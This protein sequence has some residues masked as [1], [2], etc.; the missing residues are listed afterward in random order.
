MAN[1][2]L[3]RHG[4]L[5]GALQ[6][7]CA[8]ALT[9]GL[10]LS[11]AAFAGA[12]D[13][14]GEPA[15]SALDHEPYHIS[16]HLVCD[17]SARIDDAGRA[18]LLRQWQ[19]LL[20]RF[21]GAPWVISIAPPSSPLAALDLASATPAA[22][23]KL[24]PCDKV[25]LVHVACAQSGSSLVLTGREYDVVTRRLGPLQTHEVTALVD[26][27]RALLEFTHE[28]FN[29]TAQITGQEGGKAILTVRGGSIAPAS[30]L[31]EVV[32]KGTVFMPL[33]LV[34]LKNGS[35]R[36][37]R[38]PFTYLQV[39][40]VEGSVARC[41]IVSALGD[42]LTRRVINPNTLAGLGIKPGATP[43]RLRFV[44][45][46]DGAPAA[47]YTL[48]AR[49]VPNGQAREQGATDRTGRIVLPP[50]FA[51][52][53]V[54]VRLVA[55]YVEPLVELPLVPGESSDERVIPIEPLPQTVA[56][57]AQIDSLRDEVVDLVALRA[58]LEARMKARADGEDWDG[59]EEALKEY[60]QLPPRDELAQR[61]TK[62]K[63]DATRTQAETRKAI[64]TRTAQAQITDLQS[65]IDRYL[66]DDM[67]K[68]YSEALD[69]S[70]SKAAAR[71]KAAALAKQATRA[72]APTGNAVAPAGATAHQG[73]APARAALPKLQPPP[74]PPR[75]PA[76]AA[77]NPGVPF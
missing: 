68:A 17:A 53:L 56:L 70:R 76:P 26:L 38:I 22:F 31:G 45:K 42:P 49:L 58:R 61:L 23:G 29:P 57:E 16:L 35:L 36:I 69:Q 51:D 41:A 21:I 77:Q 11:L 63:D 46:P 50:R 20:R 37:T 24:E 18:Y 14:A 7:V 64:L 39:E 30:P 34:A 71:A 1:R 48:T 8:Q 73:S 2:T 75:R 52:G 25:W 47:G 4:P 66:D 13:P 59:L 43:S 54:I 27:P 28:L 55:G 9:A 32:T 60:N 15:S 44:T 33:R 74:A 10:V 5:G 65:M 40:S 62:L 6:S 72:P 3:D 12:R 67:F 19:T